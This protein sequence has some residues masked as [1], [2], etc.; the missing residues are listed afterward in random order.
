MPCEL[1]SDLDRYLFV[2]A[3]YRIRN[4][5]KVAFF[6]AWHPEMVARCPQYC[7]PA[8]DLWGITKQS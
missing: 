8:R 2:L 5:V 4:Y 3:R 6:S 1:G 7:P